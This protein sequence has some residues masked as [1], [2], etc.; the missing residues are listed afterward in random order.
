MRDKIDNFRSARQLPLWRQHR[1]NMKHSNQT[2]II[3]G[4][5]RSSIIQVGLSVASH[6]KAKKQFVGENV[7]CRSQA[8]AILNS[9]QAWLVRN[10][11]RH[12]S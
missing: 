7:I 4:S 12:I 10:N 1:T 3:T 11:G 2:K 6:S 8:V 9:T 5:S